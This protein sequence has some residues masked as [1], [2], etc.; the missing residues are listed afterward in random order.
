MATRTTGRPS[1]SHT[2]I[3]SSIE[4]RPGATRQEELVELEHTLRGAIMSTLA[5]AAGPITIASAQRADQYSALALAGALDA[6]AMRAV[7]AHLRGQLDAGSRHLVIDL[8]RV[9]RFD[10]RL[11]AL[12]RRVEARMAARGDV[13]ELTG[14]TPRV[15]HGM[16]DDPLARVFALHRAAFERAHQPELTWATLR[17]PGGLDE[18]AEPHTAARHRAVIDTGTGRIPRQAGWRPHPAGGPPPAGDGG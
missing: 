12:L 18:V 2:G 10:E 4:A 8:S 11:T 6:S 13:L 15:L 3:F 16:D 5:E 17:C 9:A 7:G 14:L 1:A